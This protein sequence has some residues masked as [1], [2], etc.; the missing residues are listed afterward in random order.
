MNAPYD[1]WVGIWVPEA[2]VQ[3]ANQAAVQMTGDD[4]DIRSFTTRAFFSNGSLAYVTKA[5]MRES[6]YEQLP[7]LKQQLGGDFGVLATR[8]N[9][10]WMESATFDEW[11][12]R[13]DLTLESEM[14]DSFNDVLTSMEN[15]NVQLE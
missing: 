15:E 6:A 14:N 4:N 2:R 3:A 9:G 7:S 5:P 10:N 8:V 11:L 13:N 12:Q 1:R